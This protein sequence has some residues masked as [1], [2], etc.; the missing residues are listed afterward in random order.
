M[1]NTAGPKPRRG[2]PALAADKQIPLG[3]RTV[4]TK[5]QSMVACLADQY[6]AVETGQATGRPA[7]LRALVSGVAGGAWLGLYFG[8]LLGIINMVMLPAAVVWGLGSGVL[9]GG[10]FAAL[11]YGLTG[12]RRDFISGS[13]AAPGRFEVPVLATR[14]G[15]ARSIL[16][17]PAR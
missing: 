14:A 16:T 3:S 1:R 15:H 7:W 5:A 2:V 13:T 17:H 6:S 4:Y 12:R 11:G 8:L 9:F 10:T